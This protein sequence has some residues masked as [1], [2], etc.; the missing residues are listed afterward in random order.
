MRKSHARPRTR[1][2]ACAAPLP[3][4]LT[5][6]ADSARSFPCRYASLYFVMAIN[7]DDNELMTL[8]MIHRYVEILDKY[9]GNVCELDVIFNFEKAYYMLDELF[10][11]GELQETNMK[12]VL[13][14]TAQQDAMMR[15]E[16]P[17]VTRK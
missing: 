12:E 8:E 10:I 7:K 3:T 14:V 4:P 15:D 2:Q 6:C 17:G 16:D 13:R 5:A 9:F 1:P 11:G